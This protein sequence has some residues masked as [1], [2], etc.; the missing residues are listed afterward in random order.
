MKAVA[1]KAQPRN[2]QGKQNAGRLRRGGAVPGIVYGA[3]QAA[4]LVQLNEHDLLLFLKGHT[5][6]HFLVDLTVEGS[7]PC[8][9]LIKEIQRHPVSG[10]IEH[11]DFNSI[12][13]TRKLRVE[14]PVK[15][16]GEPVGVA[17]QGGV[18]D[19]IMR[20]ILV[21]CLPADIPEQLTLDVS[22]LNIGQRL[23]VADVPVDKNKLT[24]LSAADQPVAA[25]AAPRAEEE[26]A[27]TAAEAAAAAEPEVLT[28]KKPEEGEAGAAGEGKEEGKKEAGKKE[29]GKPAAAEKGKE[30]A[31]K[32]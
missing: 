25:V 9:A 15:L 13:M 2:L 17:Q 24:V 11:V 1:L 6:E 32:K 20:A 10:R 23:S 22:A 8:K 19:H 16:I 4:Q 3:D 18:L 27:P 30:E 28:A 14:V 31:K 21:E 5:S 7:K 29:A 26:V 12:S